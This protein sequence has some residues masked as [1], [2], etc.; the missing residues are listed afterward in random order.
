MA[1]RFLS[2]LFV[3]TIGLACAAGPAL[4][5]PADRFV[6]GPIAAARG[7]AASGMLP[8]DPGMDQGTFVPITIVHGV[9]SGPVLA[10]IAGVHGSEYSPILA[11]QR[12]GR[13][14]DPSEIS[15]T[16][17]LVHVANVPSFLGR[18]I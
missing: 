15:G 6:V 18:T 14:L 8:I 13:R 9:R 16:V 3:L 11:L 17:I 12:I 2:I 10:L 7:A 5:A 4:H 1:G